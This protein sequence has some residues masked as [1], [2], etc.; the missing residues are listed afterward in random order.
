M[1]W[2]RW[3]DKYARCEIRPAV[4]F[5]IGDLRQVGEADLLEIIGCGHDRWREG[6]ASHQLNPAAAE[7]AVS[8]ADHVH[9]ARAAAKYVCYKSKAR[10]GHLVKQQR[11]IALPL[12]GLRHR[13]ELV[14]AADFARDLAHRAVAS[15]LF[16]IIPHGH[17]S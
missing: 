17:Y 11:G 14:L 5:E 10:A 8:S 16:E 9:Q 12:R 3:N 7:R 1:I 2:L 6:R 13:R 4:V 15:Q